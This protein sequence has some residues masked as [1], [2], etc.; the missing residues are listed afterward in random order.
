MS[1][2]TSGLQILLNGSPFQFRG[3]NEYF[4]VGTDNGLSQWGTSAVLGLFPGINWIRI[5]MFNYPTPTQLDPIVSALTAAGVVCELEDHNYPPVLTGSSLTNSANWYASLANH[6]NGNPLV[7]YGTQNEPDLSSGW[8]AV[9][10]EISTIYSAL[11]GTGYSGLIL[12]CAAGGYTTSGLNPSVYASMTNVAW[13]L[14][15]YNWYAQNA[16]DV[17][18]NASYLQ[19]M[20]SNARATV[21]LP[22]F[23]GEFG[24]SSGANG[25]V[26][27][28]G[29][30]EV[31]TAVQQS[32]LSS[33]EWAYT[34]GD[35]S[36][37]VLLNDG[38]GNPAGGLTAAGQ[39][40][41]S[42]IAGAANVFGG[43]TGTSFT[44]SPNGTQ[45]TTASPVG[46]IDSNNNT[47]TLVASNANRGLQIATNGNIDPITGNVVFM[48]LWN[49]KIIQKNSSNNW[50]SEVTPLSGWTQLANTPNVPIYNVSTSGTYITSN[51]Q[52]AIVDMSNNKYTL[53]SANA[54]L[55]LQVAVNGTVDPV[56]QHVIVLGTVNN[57]I[58]QENS[59]NNWYSQ[60][61]PG[62]GWIQ[63]AGNPGIAI[64]NSNTSNSNTSNSNT[65]VTYIF[66]GVGSFTDGTNTY[67]IL[68]TNDQFAVNAVGI[69]NGTGT[70]AATYWA[71]LVYAQDATSNVWYNYIGYNNFVPAA[72]NPPPNGT[73]VAPPQP[74]APPAPAN[75]YCAPGQGSIVL[76]SNTY[77]VNANG[78]VILNG[79]PITGGSNASA[80]MTEANVIYKQDASG[81][82]YAWT[83]WTLATPPSQPTGTILV[84]VWDQMN[85]L[86]TLTITAEIYNAGANANTH[87]VTTGAQPTVSG[88]TKQVVPPKT[89]ANP[90]LQVTDTYTGNTTIEIQCNNGTVTMSGGTGSG[91]QKVTYTGN[92]ASAQTALASVKYTSY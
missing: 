84:S 32:G 41:A 89:N 51:T 42:F 83:G 40:A 53:V 62:S 1:I 10:T 9:D 48:A 37:P 7:V 14:H 49:N 81:N 46:I 60:V 2:T 77:T 71:N 16:T 24:I 34:S 86:S 22:V 25:A 35:S 58:V 15:F 69:P 70:G 82:W 5:N 75:T 56:T 64:A 44:P 61:T 4:D 78:F 43:G 79:T 28:P 27:D 12:L 57:S 36:F 31:V 88:N 85:A 21:N 39:V 11:R 38:D 3:I 29:G 76:G 87:G 19:Q 68:T 17:P 45:L 66:P 26:D 55:G 8:G 52:P 92:L 80:L 65:T 47:W 33:A 20:V 90:S 74:P 18:T 50:Y 91:T 67:T 63:L 13:D 6:F 73:P 72:N 23:I 59:S 30:I 54:S